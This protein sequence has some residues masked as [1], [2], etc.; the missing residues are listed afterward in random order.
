MSQDDMSAPPEGIA[1][2]VVTH[3]SAEHLPALVDALVPQLFPEDE[4]VVVDNASSDG[5]VQM[6]R[7]LHERIRVIESGGNYGE[8]AGCHIGARET[9]APL[10]LFLDPDTRPAPA[11]LARLRQAAAEHPEWAAWQAALLLEDGRINSSGGV[12][13]YLG[14]AWSGDCGR[15]VSA[16]PPSDREIG[17]PSGAAMMVRRK[18]WDALGGMDSDYFLYHEDVDW[19]LRLWLAG[20]GVGVVPGARVTHRYEFLKGSYKWH[21]LER[22]RWRTVLSVYPTSLLILLAPGLLAAELAIVLVAA[23]GGWLWPKLRAQAATLAWLPH[24]P[25]RRRAVQ[26][27]RRVSASVFAARLNASLDSPYL[28]AAQGPLLDASLRIY[29]K[30]V[31]WALSLFG[32]RNRCK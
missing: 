31:L 29:W 14:I 8:A 17:Y 3:Q 4:L 6:A 23:R 15:Q 10:L 26:R 21:F 20:R 12:V 28:T 2:V 30:F 24:L 32:S 19:G 1:V 13:H 22:N 5:T 7:S 27:T 9:R 16:L 18:D 25:A 11:C